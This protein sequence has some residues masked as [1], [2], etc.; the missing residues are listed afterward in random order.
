MNAKTWA[1]ISAVCV[2]VLVVFVGFQEARGQQAGGGSTAEREDGAAAGGVTAT[3]GGA[4]A[5]AGGGRATARAGDAVADA[6]GDDGGDTE[7]PDTDDDARSGDDLNEGAGDGGDEGL[8]SGDRRVRLAFRGAEGTAFSGECSVGDERRD[9]VGRAPER[10]VFDL[11]EEALE[12]EIR[13]GG[14]DEGPLRILLASGDDRFEQRMEGGDAT[15]EFTYSGSNLY[16]SS[17]VRGMS[18]TVP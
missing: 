15:V 10:F 7:D 18:R 2:L 13:K 4:T 17:R 5:T 12:C 11:G 3:A 9:V 1:S 16:V 8:E 14:Q 6:G